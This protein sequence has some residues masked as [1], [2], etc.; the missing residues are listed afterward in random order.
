MIQKK[1]TAYLLLSLMLLGLNSC[2]RNEM[3]V[4]QSTSKTKLD[5]LLSRKCSMLGI[6]GIVMYVHGV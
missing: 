2:T 6:I 1:I 5:H 3:P 4:K